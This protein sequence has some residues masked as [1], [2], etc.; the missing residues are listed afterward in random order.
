VKLISDGMLMAKRLIVYVSYNCH[1]VGGRQALHFFN[2]SFC[3]FVFLRYWGLNPGPSPWAILP[4]LFCDGYFQDKVLQN[5]C[6]GWLW[7]SIFLISVSWVGRII[8]MRHQHSAFFWFFLVLVW[9]W[10]FW[11]RVSL[12]NLGWLG[13]HCVVQADLKLMLLL[14]QPPKC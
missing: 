2:P 11:D 4:A 3:C 13:T 9:V 6:L 1:T 7:T 5:I 8:G 12:C 14:P 10:V